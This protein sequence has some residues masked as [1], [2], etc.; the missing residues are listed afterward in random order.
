MH[1]QQ[2]RRL[3]HG[4]NLARQLGQ[5]HRQGRAGHD[6][7]V[8][9]RR[10]DRIEQ[11]I[12]VQRG[13][14]ELGGARQRQ[15]RGGRGGRA[16]RHGRGAVGEDGVGPIAVVQRT[17]QLGD[18]RAGRDVERRQAQRRGIDAQPLEV[19][20]EQRDGVRGVERPAIMDVD[21]RLAERPRDARHD[22]LEDA[23][24]VVGETTPSEAT[25]TRMPSKRS[26]PSTTLPA[27]VSA[28]VRVTGAGSGRPVPTRATR[29]ASNSVSGRAFEVIRR[30]Q[31]G[32]L[33]FDADLVA[34]HGFERRRHVAGRDED[35]VGGRR[36]AVADRHLQEEPV[37]RGAGDPRRDDAAERDARAGPRRRSAI[38]LHLRDGMRRQARRWRGRRRRGRAGDAGR[39]VVARRRRHGGEVGQVVVGVGAAVAGAQ[40]PQIGPGSLRRAA[41]L[42]EVR[43]PVADEVDDAGQRGVVARRRSAVAHQRIDAAREHEL[44]G[45]EVQVEA[46][47][48]VRRRQGG[49]VGAGR[50]LHEVIAAR[51]HRAAQGR[52]RI[53]AE[54]LETGR[55]RVLQRQ[56]VQ[57]HG[58]LT[59]VVQ[60]D[61]IVPIGRA[62]GAAAAGYLADDDRLRLQRRRAPR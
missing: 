21:A 56:A 61:E 20:V 6:D 35:A 23:G 8:V 28:A 41:A 5:P 17:D 25:R 16:R 54:R 49:A 55:R 45:E 34:G 39:R 48:A 22:A 42:E 10:V 3:Q 60:L 27:G 7:V 11:P 53:L 59:D 50:Q 9:V 43:G 13:G 44:A 51:R 47:E 52:D 33:A 32:D 24:P 14:R 31:L 62:A 18:H 12:G 1:G 15:G 26:R 30:H 37:E 36:V 40:Q 57:D 29:L 46:A 4:A 2:V 58:R 19:G 38:A